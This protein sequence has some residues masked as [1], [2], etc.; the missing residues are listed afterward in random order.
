MFAAEEN[1]GPYS[2]NRIPYAKKHG[3]TNNVRKENK[4][5]WF[6]SVYGRISINDVELP[7]GEPCTY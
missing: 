4:Y 2:W 5:D 6:Y 7:K 1:S 3:V